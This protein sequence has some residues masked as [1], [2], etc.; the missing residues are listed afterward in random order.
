MEKKKTNEELSKQLMD[1]VDKF[2]KTATDLMPKGKFTP[3]PTD[4]L[5][6]FGSF[7]NE[8]TEKPFSMVHFGSFTGDKKAIAYT[9][10]HALM[11]SPELIEPFAMALHIATERLSG[12]DKQIADS[13]TPKGEC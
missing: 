2:D 8:P 13:I 11:Q 12:G 4:S 9:L 5:V 1:L 7:Q 10:T 3:H 6:L